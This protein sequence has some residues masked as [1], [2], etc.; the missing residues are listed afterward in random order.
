MFD[1]LE[2]IVAAAAKGVRPPERLTVDQAAVRYRKMNNPGNYVG[3]WMNETTPYLKEP[4]QVLTSLRYTGMTFVGPAQCGKT[5]LWLNWQTY[6]V[7]CDPADMMLVQTS[8]VTASDFKKRRID[9]LHRD[10]PDVR[11]ELLKGRNN[12]NMFD[13]QYTNGALITLG[14]P[15]VN[16]L[17][18]KPIP[19]MFLTDYDRMDQDVEKNGSPFKLS[20]ARGTSFGQNRMTVA[21]SS[22]SFPITDPIW[23]P[24]TPHEAPPC[25]GILGLYNTGDRRRWYWIC[26]KCNNAFQPDFSL[27]KWPETGN[28]KQ[29]ARECYMVCPHCDSQYREQPGDLPGKYE[30]NLAGLWLRDGEMI[31]PDGEIVGD[32]EDSSMASFW[33]KGVCASF[34]K[35]EVIVEKFLSALRTYHRTGV[36]T[37]LKGTVNVDQGSPYKPKSS[38]S[39]RLPED[40]KAGALDYGHKV[41]P[42]GVRFLVATIDVQ[43]NRFVV[44]INGVAQGQDVYVVDRFE[45]KY[46]RREVED[47]EGQV[48]RV[49]PF[50]YAEDWH[51]IYEEV[52]TKSYELGDGSGR[53]MAIKLTI[54]DSGGGGDGKNPKGTKPKTSNTAN[55]YAFYRWLKTGPKETDPDFRYWEERWQPGFADRFRLYQGN[56]S[57]TAP[58]TRVSYPDSGRKDRLAEARGEIPILQANVTPLKNSLDAALTRK[59]M[60]SGRINFA[61]WL[62]INFFKELCVEV[63]DHRGVW[64]N[65]KQFRNESWDLLVMLFAALVES[66]LLN[67]ERIDWSKASGW[68]AD[69]DYNDLVFSEEAETPFASKPKRKY[70]LKELAQKLG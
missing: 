10:S 36:E 68:T 20:D 4:M 38:E 50:V 34:Q 35:W 51:L 41:V 16:H 44:Q 60:G 13:M 8:Q 46:S 65:P 49:T 69:W 21:E 11:Q 61:N 67:A 1:S 12:D 55:A 31:T 17:S 32:F 25:E 15:T 3:D 52:L 28:I 27:M 62:D 37:D 2:D 29:M 53:R 58:R 6:T 70:D 30:M 59:V 56:A 7:V 33:L 5:E 64:L 24:S 54:T 43:N 63:K 9:R 48:H 47:R 14:W 45:I 18:G 19:R 42:P 40:M 66:T 22:P 23:A 57:F 26:V 39:D